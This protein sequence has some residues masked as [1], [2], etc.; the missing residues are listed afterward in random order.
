[1]NKVIKD[2]TVAVLVPKVSGTYWFTRHKLPQLLFDPVVVYLVQKLS[3]SHSLDIASEIEYYCDKT[4]G[5]RDYW[6]DSMYL[7]VEYI[8]VSSMFSVTLEDDR[9]AISIPSLKH[10]VFI[11]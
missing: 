4:Y 1:M 2:N 11:A 5:E 10:E 9:E 8:S 7:T 3:K 6:G